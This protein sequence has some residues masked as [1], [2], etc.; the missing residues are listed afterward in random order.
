ME[1][2]PQICWEKMK[3]KTTTKIIFFLNLPR[4]SSVTRRFLSLSGLWLRSLFDTEVYKPFVVLGING[5][6]DDIEFEADIFYSLWK[7]NKKKKFRHWIIQRQPV[8]MKNVLSEKID[9]WIKAA[10][11]LK[12][13]KKKEMIC[14][15]YYH[16]Q[17]IYGMQ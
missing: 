1:A 3:F 6:S 16:K 12:W 17:N 10:V 13:T 2:H 9:V 15:Q 4:S 5:S 7:I 14:T 11:F 8:N